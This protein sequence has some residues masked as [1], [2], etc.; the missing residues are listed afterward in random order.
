M[1]GTEIGESRTFE[2]F[3][4]LCAIVAAG[5]GF[6]YSITFVV[7]ARGSQ[8]TGGL[9]S[10]LFMMLGGLFTLPVFVAI[11]QRLRA[12]DAGFALWA[13]LLGTFGALG[14]AVHGGYDVANFFNPPSVSAAAL[15]NQIDPRGLLTFGLSGLAVFVVAHL[16][17]RGERFP[18]PLGTLGYLLSI[19]LIIL[20]LGRLIV[21]NPASPI[22]LIP[23]LLTGFIVHPAWYLWL[24]ISLLRGRPT[25]R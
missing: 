13:L 8:G 3:S 17:G 9:L 2:G 1:P 21:L 19:L 15:P 22:I 7:M 12:T 5:S 10:P 4:G 11:F 25:D 23:A 16:I 6:L 14:S 24:G 20:Y 18:R